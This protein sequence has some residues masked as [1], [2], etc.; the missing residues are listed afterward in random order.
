[1]DYL[2]HWL[3][4]DPVS[5]DSSSLVTFIIGKN[6]ETVNFTAHKEVICCHS[7]VLEAAFNSNFIEGQTQTCRLEDTTEDAFKLFMQWIYSQRLT[8]KQLDDC[9]TT[10]E[11]EEVS[12]Y[13]NLM[14]L[15]VLA[16]RLCIPCLQNAVITAADEIG[17]EHHI[18]RPESCEYV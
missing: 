2:R 5:S 15:W 8:L 3:I 12:E 6:G 9:W 13:M 1:M 17:E 16:D 10:V 7:P 18:L 14:G 11:A 4:T